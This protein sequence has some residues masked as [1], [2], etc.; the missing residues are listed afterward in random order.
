[1]ELAAIAGRSSLVLTARM[2]AYRQQAAAYAPVCF[3]WLAAALATG[4]DDNL[5]NVTIKAFGLPR[6]A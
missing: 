3:M 6:V 1:M 4:R 5:M 2:I